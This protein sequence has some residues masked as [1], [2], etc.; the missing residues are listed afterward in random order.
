[1]NTLAAL[2]MTLT[3]QSF[4]WTK[5][6]LHTHAYIDHNLL[7]IDS[8]LQHKSAQ[9]E[10]IRVSSRLQAALSLRETADVIRETVLL[11]QIAGHYVKDIKHKG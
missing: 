7:N 9:C 4:Y 6:P 5:L 2:L 10:H 8:N 3:I 11:S 1:M